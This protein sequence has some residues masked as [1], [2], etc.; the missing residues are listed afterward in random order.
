[1]KT[2]VVPLASARTTSVIVKSDSDIV[3]FN[4]VMAISFHLVI[5]PA[6]ISANVLPSN[7][8]LPA[9]MPLRLMEQLHQLLRELIVTILYNIFM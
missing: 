6:N 9:S 7:T 8:N 5:L 4:F 1:V 2:A 3:G